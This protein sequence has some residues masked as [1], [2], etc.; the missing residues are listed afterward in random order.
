[1]PETG[2]N[3][4]RA[5]K[6]STESLATGAYNRLREAILTGKLRPN[7]QLVE[8][9]L[10]DWL[11]VSRTPLRESLIR[12]ASE[13]LVKSRRRAW[14]VREYTA[15]EV[16][17]IHEV[18]AALEGMAVFIAAERATDEQIEHIVAFHSHQNREALEASPGAYL[19]EYND[20]FHEE[21]VAMAGNERL[22]E[23]IR[24]NRDFFFTYRI[25]NLYSEEEAHASLRGHD[26]IIEAL[27]DRDGERGEGAAR[28][29]ILEARDAIIAKLY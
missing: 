24:V 19:V 17:E 14:V 2:E 3:G 25:A 1:V 20:A 23:F 5:Q 10:A 6:E 18:R 22:R 15:Q 9:E 21:I 26:E 4:K 29:H 27:R 11:E 12:L 7:E 16:T 8:A 13:G 28:A